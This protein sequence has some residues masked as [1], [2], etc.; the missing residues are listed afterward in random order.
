MVDE[1]YSIA[2]LSFCHHPDIATPGYALAGHGHPAYVLASRFEALRQPCF[3][4][5]T[6]RTI[7]PSFGA[8]TGGFTVTPESGDDIYVSS[9][10]AVHFVR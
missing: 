5:G 9:G 7:L 1:P 4:V 2:P 10:E 3:V 6:A 8:F